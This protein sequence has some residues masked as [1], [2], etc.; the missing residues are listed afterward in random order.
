VIDG[1]VDTEPPGDPELSPRNKTGFRPLGLAQLVVGTGIAVGIFAGFRRRGSNAVFGAG[2]AADAAYGT[3]GE[4][5]PVPAIGDPLADVPTHRVPDGR[6]AELATVEFSPP[7]GIEPWQGNVLLRE[8]VGDETVS[9]WFSEM[10]ARGAIEITGTGKDMVLRPG[11][12]T[13]RL[14]T[15]DRVHLVGLFSGGPAV[16]L[17]SHSSSFT[18]VWNGIKT[19]QERVI[20]DSGWWEKPIGSTDAGAKAATLVIGLMIFGIMLFLAA[21]AVLVFGLAGS[22]ATALLLT[23]VVAAVFAGLAYQTMLA[24]RTATGS[25][26]TLRTESFRRFLEASEGRHV[27]WAWDNGLIREY[28]AWAVALGAAGAWSKAI[29]SSNVAHPEQFTTPLLLHTYSANFTQTHT[30]PSSSG[31]S[32]GFSGGVGGGGGGGSSGSW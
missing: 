11:Q 3:G 32:G 24:S 4:A 6:L 2:G 10:I 12:T 16:E 22:V 5:L 21:A 14:S 15:V 8:R 29:E 27:D 19:E 23:I 18:N 26:L 13:A 31:G 9:A 25:A 1:F 30:A 28:S 7:R 20:K 17:G